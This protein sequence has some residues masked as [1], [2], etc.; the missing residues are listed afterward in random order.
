MLLSKSIRLIDCVV[1]AHRLKVFWRGKKAHWNRGLFCILYQEQG[2]YYLCM[3]VKIYFKVW[4]YCSKLNRV[5]ACLA[6]V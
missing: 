2:M 1:E 5:L 3:Y 6:K 4:V